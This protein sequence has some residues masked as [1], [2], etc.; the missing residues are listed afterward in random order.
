MTADQYDQHLFFG[1]PRHQVDCSCCLSCLYST[2]EATSQNL[3]HWTIHL[4]KH[5][6]IAI[7]R[8]FVY[9]Y[10]FGKRFADYTFSMTLYGGKNLNLEI[11]SMIVPES[12]KLDGLVSSN[13]C[14]DY[15]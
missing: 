2:M 8:S 13:D 12:D 14:F 6:L 5:M 3:Y 9:S 4:Y 15:T 7:Q 10:M 11:S 1:L